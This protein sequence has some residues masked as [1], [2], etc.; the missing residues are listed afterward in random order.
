MARSPKPPVVINSA[1]LEE[2]LDKLAFVMSRAK[3]ASIYLPLWK[4]LEH[5]LDMQRDVENVLAAA[6]ARVK[7]SKHR[8][9]ARS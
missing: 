3:D 1:K 6:A 5:E 9:E 2:C 8:T 4:R 7:R